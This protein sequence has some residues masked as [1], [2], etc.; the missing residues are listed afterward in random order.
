MPATPPLPASRPLNLW[1]AL[2][3]PALT[4]FGLILLELTDLDMA[5]AK[6]A[7]DRDADAVRQFGDLGPAAEGSP[8]GGGDR[9]GRGGNRGG[10]RGGR[11]R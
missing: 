4:A 11:R 2:G 3:I 8:R 10:N 7:F 6:L 1:I 5:L 9:D